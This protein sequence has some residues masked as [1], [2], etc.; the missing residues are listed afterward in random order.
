LLS[1]TRTLGQ[2]TGIAVMS[3]IWAGRVAFYLAARGAAEA[4]RAPAAV[5]VAALNDTF[6]VAIVLL[7]LALALAS[8]GLWFERRRA[9]SAPKR[10]R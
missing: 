6:R 3:A 5:Q 7:T 4:T 2:T 9:R 10:G 1:V 8:W